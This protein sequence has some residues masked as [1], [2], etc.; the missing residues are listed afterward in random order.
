MADCEDA[1]SFPESAMRRIALALSLCLGSAPAFAAD[2]PSA[3][4]S[5]PAPAS[6]QAP[7]ADIDHLLQVVDAQSMMEG[8]MKQMF[9]SQQAMM[10]DAFGK[11]LSDADRVRMQDLSTKINAITMKHMSWTALEPV[12]RKVYSQVFDKQEVDAM[13]AFYSTPE[14]ASILKKSPQVLAATMHEIQPLAREAMTEV[15]AMIDEEAAK[16]SKQ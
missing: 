13:I 11:D 16:K 15:K 6:M 10:Q 5:V 7:D 9:A 14:G 1:A 12:M 8:I 2:P 3:P 4:S